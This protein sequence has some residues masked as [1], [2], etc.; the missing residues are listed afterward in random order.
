MYTDEEFGPTDPRLSDEFTASN[1][2]FVET[3]V[4]PPYLPVRM[5]RES[6]V[7]VRRI[8]D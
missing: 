7:F 4:L 5:V 3:C 2:E 6:F 1:E 8:R